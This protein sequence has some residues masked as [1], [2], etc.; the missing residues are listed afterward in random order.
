MELP[1]WIVLAD[2]DRARILE[3]RKPGAELD[4]VESLNSTEAEGEAADRRF[5][6]RLAQRLEQ[7]L[8]E[9]RFERFRVAATPRFLPLLREAVQRRI[10]LNRAAL[11]WLQEDYLHLNRHR[12]T[13]LLYGSEDP[14][15]P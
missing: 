10:D 8:A 6:E 9:A 12:V 5:A 2:R 4:D 7:A 14:P 11:D 1:M 13:R 15:E 3:M